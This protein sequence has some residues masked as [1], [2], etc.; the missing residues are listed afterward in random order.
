MYGG[1]V[2]AG[3]T[4]V[5]MWLGQRRVWMRKRKGRGRRGVCVT[6]SHPSETRKERFPVLT[7]HFPSSSSL[8]ALVLPL[9]GLRTHSTSVYKTI[10]IVKADITETC[11]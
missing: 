10:D 7:T 8:L 1:L 2:E 5:A 9:T 11:S 4:P 6:E 3:L